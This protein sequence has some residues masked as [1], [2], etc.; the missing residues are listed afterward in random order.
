MGYVYLVTTLL[1]TAYG[2][3]AFK[4]QIDEA[5]TFPTEPGERLEYLARLAANPWMVSVSLSVLGAAL[6]WGAALTRFELNFA[7]R[8]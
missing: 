8:L 7:Y 6:V 1:L 5:G 3:L 4:R 2:Q